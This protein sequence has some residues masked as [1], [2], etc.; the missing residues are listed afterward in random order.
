M[1]KSYTRI[2]T[3][4]FTVMC[5]SLNA[6]DTPLGTPATQNP[7]G[8]TDTPGSPAACAAG[9]SIYTID[10]DDENIGFLPGGF[11]VT[12]DLMN[13]GTTPI[14]VTGTPNGAGIGD[15]DNI[16]VDGGRINYSSTDG[17]N[18]DATYNFCETVTNPY[19]FIGDLETFTTINFFDCS[20]NP[21]AINLMNG[22][23]RF[24]VSGNSALIT[25]TTSTNQDGYVQVPGSYDCLIINIDNPAPFTLDVIQISVGVCM[26]DPPSG[27]MT[28]P[29][30]LYMWKKDNYCVP[31]YR[32]ADGVFYEKDQNNN[33]IAS[34]GDEFFVDGPLCGTVEFLEA[35]A[36]DD[37][38][39][40]PEFTCD[41]FPVELEYYEPA[42]DGCL[43]STYWYDI[44][45]FPIN[46]QSAGN[47]WSAIFS[48]TD[49]FGLPAHPSTP[50]TAAENCGLEWVGENE[51]DMDFED[52][53]GGANE[54]EQLQ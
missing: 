12:T 4:L 22:Q 44:T 35:N 21:V 36:I 49:A 31:V 24:A 3:L 28:C 34:L 52:E 8:S 25:G 38:A 50:T 29:Y 39:C 27:N 13:N 2:F 7:D 51:G 41:A 9:F 23:S 40:E 20:G 37:N 46:D 19:V 5:F 18:L 48:G 26:P 43:Y 30:D 6:Q 42:G 10:H 15:V 47:Q 11:C 33:N 16:V 17:G 32:D 45:S 14:T 54:D 1:R 53:A